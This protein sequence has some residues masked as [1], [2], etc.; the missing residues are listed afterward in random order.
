M[1]LLKNNNMIPIIKRREKRF[2]YQ[3]LIAFIT[4]VDDVAMCTVQDISLSGLS[5]CNI[6]IKSLLISRHYKVHVK[7]YGFDILLVCRPCWIKI[8]DCREFH[9]IGFKIINTSYIWKLF[10]DIKL[11]EE[12]NDATKSTECCHSDN[13][14]ISK[15]HLHTSLQIPFIG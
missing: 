11:P 9:E 3:G 4:S 10:L 8:S 14:L 13:P 1:I 12:F 2:S 15:D 5:I 7:G 6:R